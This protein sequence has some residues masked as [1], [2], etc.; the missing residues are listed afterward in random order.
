MVQGTSSN[1]GKSTLVAAFC[2]L[3]ARAG[4]RVAPF[5]AQNMSNNAAVT[6]DGGEVGRAQAMQAAAAGVPVTVDMNP[7][8]L[9]PQSDRTSQVVVLGRARHVCD[10]RAYHDRTAELWP[11]VTGALDRLRAAYDLVVIEGAGSPAEINLERYDIVNMRVARHADAP[12]VLVGDIDRGGVFASLY[13]TVALLPAHDR[14]RVR[15]FIINKFRGDPSLLDSGFVMLEE[16]TG[17]PTLGVLPHLDLTGLPAEDAFEWDRARAKQSRTLITVT[18]ARLPHVANLDEF[19]PL[20]RE[21]LVDVRWVSTAAELG[22]PDLIVIPGTKSTMADLAWLRECGL[23]S[24]IVA[25]AAT[26]TSVLG[27]CGGYQMLGTRITD[28]DAVESSGSAEG[29]GLLPVT[30][31]FSTRKQTRRVVAR[32]T[33]DSA[34]WCERDVTEALD[35]YEI[36]MGRTTV[37]PGATVGPA[38]FV[39]EHGLD[40]T[41][42]G[43]CS[44]DGLVVGTYVHGLLEN[45]SLRGALL[46]RLAARKGVSLPSVQP[47]ATFGTAIDNLAD[48]VRDNLDCLAIGRLVGLSID[49]VNA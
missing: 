34:L 2:R 21:P 35:G 45:A 18:I 36:H 1:A 9:K 31:A 46:A 32:V 37:V 49:G 12:V 29:L 27:I 13:G 22:T 10:A 25:R 28:E 20:M 47:A 6:D 41:S 15:G 40:R 11:V 5:K 30:T 14:A 33:G 38:P 17:I 43:C 39:A 26:G 16:R 23:G 7:V 8:L 24:A 44:A 3:F 42:D 48:A 19:Q 4:Y